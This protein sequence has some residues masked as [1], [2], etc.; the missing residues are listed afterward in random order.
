MDDRR[1]REGTVLTN[2]AVLL[3]LIDRRLPTVVLI[4]S[5]V[6]WGV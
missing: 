2:A 1:L 4:V 3:T 5:P 6:N